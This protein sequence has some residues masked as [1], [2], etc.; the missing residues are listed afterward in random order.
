MKGKTFLMAAILS[1]VLT[2]GISGTS[3]AAELS[4]NFSTM[5][6]ESQVLSHHHRHIPPP[7]PRHHHYD[8]EY[9]GRTGY[10]NRHDNNRYSK[11]RNKK[12]NIN[13]TVIRRV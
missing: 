9:Y 8:R 2:F 11:T 12:V 7:P 13:V 4:S 3:S 5:Q 10:G 6:V 1:A